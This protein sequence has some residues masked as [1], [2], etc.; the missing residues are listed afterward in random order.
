MKHLLQKISLLLMAMFFLPIITWGQTATKPSGSGTAEDPYRIEILEHLHWISHTD[1]VWDDHFIQIADIDASLTSGWDNDSGFL[2][3]AHGNAFKGYYNGK[4]YSIE[5]LYINRP[6][7]RYVGLFS[8]LFDDIRIDSIKLEDLNIS[9]ID[10][11]GGGLAGK[12]AGTINHCSASGSISGNRN[13]GGLVGAN[14]GTIKNSHSSC[15]VTSQNSPGY[16]GGLVG[17]NRDTIVNS[18]STGDI[19]GVDNLGGLVG[20]NEID[21][22]IINSY[23]K[24][25]VTGDSIIGGLVGWNYQAEITNSYSTGTVTGNKQVG[26]LVGLVEPTT[27]TT[28]SYWD[29]ETSG[30]DTSLDGTGRS[31]AEMLSD[32]TYLNNTWDFVCED[33]NG[34]AN[35]WAM[36][37][38]MNDGYPILAWQYVGPVPTLASLPDV[39]G[40]GSAEVTETPTA[41]D[42]CGNEIDG[43]T[44]DPLTYDSEGTYTVTWTYEDSQGNTTTQEQTVTVSAPDGINELEKAGI[45]LY[46]NPVDDKI[47]IR[48]TSEQV[49]R[50]VVTDLSG[51]VCLQKITNNQNEVLNLSKLN[52]GIYLI[53]LETEKGKYTAKIVKK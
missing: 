4:D 52:S 50:V 35:V 38:G 16:I 51:R 9:G 45:N 13:T 12:N 8:I 53:Q 1:S 32:T 5:G 29:K 10:M 47:N 7:K 42:T 41:Q 18:Y 30:I 31:T 33:A 2:P 46:P 3:I 43:T 37:E 28:H 23:S 27:N 19:N 17:Y 40:T 44:E 39:T 22:Y 49:S 26:G 24:S 15:T 20:L 34:T 25:S 36:L 14:Y 21:S 48:S 6:N 11:H